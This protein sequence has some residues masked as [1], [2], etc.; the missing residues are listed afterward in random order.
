ML[1]SLKV[2]YS[3]IFPKYRFVAVKLDATTDLGA[4]C[5]PTEND[6]SWYR[7]DCFSASAYASQHKY[8]RQL[9]LDMTKLRLTQ[10]IKG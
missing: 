1:L 4:F 10:L 8:D 6:Q 3:V 9:V 2:H 7:N 5:F